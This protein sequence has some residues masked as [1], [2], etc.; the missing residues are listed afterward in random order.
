M[1]IAISGSQGCGK[2]TL[3][4]QLQLSGY[5]CVARKTSR[6]IL[7]DWNVS[8]SEVN[9]NHELTIKFQDEILKRK[10]DDEQDTINEYP[11]HTIIFT[12]RSFTDLFVYALIALGKD[13]QYSDYL[14][15][16]YDKCV[17]AQ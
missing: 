8:L 9:N 3:I 14:D 16:Y 17:Q 7:T 10:I 15:Q 12:E 5:N 6:S 1:L 13:N 11:E 4:Q 2:S